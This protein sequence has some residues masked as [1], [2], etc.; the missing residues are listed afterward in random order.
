MDIEIR[1]LRDGELPAVQQLDGRAF[2]V[3]YSEQDVDD[4]ALILETD[5]FLVAADGDALVGAAGIFSKQLSV[6][7]GQRVPSAGVTWVSTSPTHRRRGVLRALMT[8]Q[9]DDVAAR[10]EPLA[11]LTASEGS[12][13]GRFGYGVA[14]QIRRIEIDKRRGALRPE[15]EVTGRCRYVAGDEAEA[16]LPPI[17]DALQA[18]LPGE[19]DRS[20]AWWTF[21]FRDREH[22][23]G[24][25]SG[26]FD[27]VHEAAGGAVDGYLTYR[28]ADQGDPGHRVRRF[29]VVDVAA[30]TPA[31]HAALWHFAL[32]VDLVDTVASYRLAL[33]DPLPWMLTDSRR[34]RTTL[35][36]DSLWVRVL[37]A[38][39]ALSARAYG[40]ND[41]L[42]LEVRDDLRGD[43]TVAVEGGPDGGKAVLAGPAQTPD[44][45]LGVSELGSIYLGGLRPSVLARAGRIIEVTPG[46]LRRADHF[47][48]WDRLPLLLT[49]F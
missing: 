47:F 16:L 22:Q 41:R 27:V 42:V 36:D 31:A 1:P 48:S 29:E 32:N 6:P 43:V 44:L 39:A 8:R 37:D 19:V 3:H 2:G 15:V 38:P 49:G 10:G 34:V 46:A 12:I 4:L 26:R 9:L 11:I 14:T 23:R 21:L 30:L 40:A 35:L 24:G 5:R 18:Q 28:I 25:A 7:G 33:D 45:R 17:H 20:E 13:Y